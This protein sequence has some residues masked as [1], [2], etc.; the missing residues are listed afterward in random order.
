M[1]CGGV[2][3]ASLAILGLQ[4][5]LIAVPWLYLALKVLG[6]AYLAYLGYKIWRGAKE[7][8]A[9]AQPNSAAVKPNYNRSFVLGL[10]TQ[11]SN[12]KTAVVYTSIFAALLPPDLPVAMAILLAVLV[13]SIETGWYSIVA[14]ALSATQPR[15]AYLRSKAAIDRTTGGVMMLL[16]AKLIVASGRP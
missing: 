5:L 14:L 15:E 1:G 9:V 4:A 12:P 11:L 6:G 2:I 7:G 8:L 16:G 10:A 3:F 13:F